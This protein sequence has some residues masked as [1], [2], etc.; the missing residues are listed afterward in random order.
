[1]PLKHYLSAQ[2][3][4]RI[5]E[6]ERAHSLLN[7]GITLFGLYGP[8]G[9]TTRML[10][11]ESGANSAAITYYFGSK[12][13][14]YMATMQH[15][16]DGIN[17]LTDPIVEKVEARLADG[18]T[19]EEALETFQELM[20]G[21]STLFIEDNGVEEWSPMIMREHAVPTD[22]YKIFYEGYYERTQEVFRQLIGL[23][24][25]ENPKSDTVMM[26]AHA[27]FGQ[28]LGFLIARESLRQGLR[29]K[30][31]NKTHHRM[32]KDIIR[33]NTNAILGE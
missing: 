3:Q 20:E 19:K 24:C 23:L 9:T 16:V 17:K 13:G 5:A 12:Q 6:S 33:A 4:E 14:L 11:D 27:L 1:M 31:I 32:M 30:Q 15:I 8:E 29:N 22:A 28:S 25:D 21:F 2:Q 7:A 10:A 26:K 18:L